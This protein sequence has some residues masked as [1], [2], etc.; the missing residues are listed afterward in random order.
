MMGRP[1]STS[2]IIT[3]AFDFA[4]GFE[5][6][7]FGRNFAFEKPKADFKSLYLSRLIGGRV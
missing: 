7:P 3:A 6:R 4:H 2:G 5:L 1:G